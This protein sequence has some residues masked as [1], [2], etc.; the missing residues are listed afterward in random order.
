[1]ELRGPGDGTCM[2]VPR[3]DPRC[4][5][6]K[7]REAKVDSESVRKYQITC[8]KKEKE[9]RKKKSTVSIECNNHCMRVCHLSSVLI[10]V[11][12]QRLLETTQDV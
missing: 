8:H 1:M 4:S 10:G 2:L 12:Y 7:G 3:L 9:K 6:N 5:T 11:L